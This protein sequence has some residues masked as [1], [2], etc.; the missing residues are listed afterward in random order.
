MWLCTVVGVP[1]LQ[2]AS[3]HDASGQYGATEVTC[4][5]VTFGGS[6]GLK[7]ALLRNYLRLIRIL[8]P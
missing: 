3:P 2:F 6:S 7:L 1:V 4:E 5:K 8:I